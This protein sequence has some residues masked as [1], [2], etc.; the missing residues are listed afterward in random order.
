MRNNDFSSKILAILDPF[1]TNFK[2]S[3]AENENKQTNKQKTIKNNDTINISIKQLL[4]TLYIHSVVTD[5]WLPLLP[6]D[7]DH[8][9]FAVT[10]YTKLNSYDINAPNK[11]VSNSCVVVF[12]DE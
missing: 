12:Y 4:L 8:N 6:N 3:A 5:S 7:F 1:K 11:T 9:I 10:L 2:M